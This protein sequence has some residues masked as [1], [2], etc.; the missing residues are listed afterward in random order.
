MEK[1]LSLIR[2]VAYTAAGA[3]LSWAVAARLRD[4]QQNGPE[5]AFFETLFFAFAIACVL[6]GGAA[7]AFLSYVRRHPTYRSDVILCGVT[8]LLL[9][10]VALVCF[11]RYGGV[12][13]A[14]D[15]EGYRIVNWC[16]VLLSVLPLPFFLRAGAAAI[17]AGPDRRMNLVKRI[18]ALCGMAL[19]AVLIITGHLFTALSYTGGVAA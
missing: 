10:V 19:Y 17:P 15:E 1:Y 2:S 5:N 18:V 8:G 16:T 12:S 6:I 9:M 7:Y 14:F 3:L 11:L 13:G 4:M